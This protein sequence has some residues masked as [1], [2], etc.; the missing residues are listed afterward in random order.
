MSNIQNPLLRAID[1]CS[2]VSSL[3]AAIGENQ[4]TVS[5]WKSRDSVPSKY[6]DAIESAVSSKVTA[7]DFLEYE[8]AKKLAISAA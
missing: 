3:A 4:T 2:G 6:W 7:I 8:R 5:M 1:I